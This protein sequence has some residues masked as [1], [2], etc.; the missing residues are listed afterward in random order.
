MKDAVL[1]RAFARWHDASIELLAEAKSAAAAAD[2]AAAAATAEA[3]QQ[4]HCACM[5][6][7]YLLKMMYKWM[8]IALAM[9]KFATDVRFFLR[10]NEV[11]V[12]RNRESF[13]MGYQVGD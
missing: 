1:A 11:R 8:A 12:S 6:R 10:N 13:R 5:V 7:R 2:A 9:W 3:E 4:Q